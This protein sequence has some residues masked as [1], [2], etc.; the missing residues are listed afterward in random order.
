M[1][2]QC[3]LMTH[4]NKLQVNKKKHLKSVG[5]TLKEQAL[6]K[7]KEQDG[8]T[9]AKVKTHTEV[10]SIPTSAACHN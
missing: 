3:F 2:K 5:M 10:P 7:V 8:M 1:V 9:L 4:N 6:A